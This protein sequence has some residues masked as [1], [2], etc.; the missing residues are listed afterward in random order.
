ML[1]NAQVMLKTWGY[2]A[3]AICPNAEAD[4]CAGGILLLV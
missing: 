4:L 3:F 2:D 1:E